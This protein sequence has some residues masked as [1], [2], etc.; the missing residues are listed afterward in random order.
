[1]AARPKCSRGMRSAQDAN[2]L[3]T[4]CIK[5]LF[6]VGRGISDLHHLTHILHIKS[7]HGPENHIGSRTTTRYITGEDDSV[8]QAT[9]P[10]EALHNQTPNSRIETSIY[11]DL[12]ASS[13][14]ESECL[15]RT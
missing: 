12:N 14:Q 10:F 2:Y 15:F 3:A 9:R 7:L 11:G 1:M 8:D 5:A 13:T 6:Q 4:P